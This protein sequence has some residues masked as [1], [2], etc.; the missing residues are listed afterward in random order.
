MKKQTIALCL[1]FF[2]F[3]SASLAQMTLIRVEVNGKIGFGYPDPYKKDNNGYPVAGSIIIPAI[4][5]ETTGF[6]ET[7]EGLA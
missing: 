1:A 6:A 2:A 5:D 3:F 4:Y 7:T